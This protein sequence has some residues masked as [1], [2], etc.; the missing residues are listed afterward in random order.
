[1]PIENPNDLPLLDGEIRNLKRFA[2]PDDKTWSLFNPSIA[3]SPRKG[4]A[5]AFRSSNYVILKTG[6]LHV[7]DL[8]KIQNRI[9]FADVDENLQFKNLREIEVPTTLVDT[10]RG[11]EDPKLFWR[12]TSWYFTATMLERH[13]PV[14]RMA[15]CKLDAKATKVTEIVV[16]DGINVKTPEKNWMTPDLKKSPNF[17]FIHGPT[18]IVVGDKVIFSKTS[19]PRMLGLRGNTHLLEQPDGTYIAVMHRLWA[20][21]TYTYMP[22]SFGTIRGKD[23]NYAHFFVRFDRFGTM[24]QISEPFQFISPGIEFAAGIIEHENNFVISFGK[25]DVSSHLCIVSKDTALEMMKD[26]TP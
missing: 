14:A 15:V 2:L 11:M 3:K 22:N 9:Y 12:G 10:R 16:Q 23:K 6:E 4:M 24:I 13:T 26:V 17:D 21:T 1:M 7:T 19:D 18:S 20:K 25:N 8:E 5:M